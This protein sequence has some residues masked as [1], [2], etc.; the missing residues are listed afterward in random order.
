VSLRPHH[1]LSTGSVSHIHGL[2]F[3]SGGEFAAAVEQGEAV[4]ADLL[5]GDRPINET[6]QRLTDAIR[7]TGVRGLVKWV[8]WLM[9]EEGEAAMQDFDMSDKES[10]IATLVSC[11]GGR[12][13]QSAFLHAHPDFVPLSRPHATLLNC[14][15]TKFGLGLVRFCL[16]D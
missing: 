4:G 13:R 9:S 1:A 15:S 12:L 6:S 5:P 8:K 2:G 11:R 7:D 14:C 16:T 3:D 10:V